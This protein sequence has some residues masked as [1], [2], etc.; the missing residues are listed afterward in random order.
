MLGNGWPRI[1]GSYSK[2]LKWLGCKN[3]LE[4]HKTGLFVTLPSNNLPAYPAS[5]SKYTHRA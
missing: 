4:A 3:N 1:G 5:I 2:P